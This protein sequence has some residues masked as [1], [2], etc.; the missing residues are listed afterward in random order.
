MSSKP[1]KFQSETQKIDTNVGVDA[2]DI[3][4]FDVDLHYFTFLLQMGVAYN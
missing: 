1:T 2:H 3:V 4:E